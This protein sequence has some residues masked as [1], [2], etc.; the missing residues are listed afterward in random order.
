MILEVETNTWQVYK[1]LDA[2]LAEL[3]W[4]TD[5]RALENEW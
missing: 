2:S 4:I 5:T 1:R 3:L